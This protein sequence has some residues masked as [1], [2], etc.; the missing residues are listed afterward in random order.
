M[1]HDRGDG[2]MPVTLKELPGSKTV[3][4]G[5]TE[6]PLT[7]LLAK[8]VEPVTDGEFGPRGARLFR[9]SLPSGLA[10]MSR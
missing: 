5:V 3:S 7:R 9:K 6:H 8:T 2:K 10:D 4:R 1:A